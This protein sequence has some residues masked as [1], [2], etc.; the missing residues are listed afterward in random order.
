MRFKNRFALSSA[1][2]N[3]RVPKV[4]VKKALKKI[5]FRAISR[6]KS[7]IK[8]STEDAIEDRKNSD[9]ATYMRPALKI[10]NT[11]I[12]VYSTSRPENFE[13]LCLKF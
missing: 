8:N 4:K 3:N 13:A 1:L 11:W 5:F 9:S 10:H 2:P 7:C 12:V 6:D